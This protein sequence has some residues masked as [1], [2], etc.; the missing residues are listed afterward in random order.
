VNS[1]LK[2]ETAEMICFGKA[3]LADQIS[4]ICATPNLINLQSK[5]ETVDFYIIKTMMAGNSNLDMLAA[6]ATTQDENQ[7]KNQGTVYEGA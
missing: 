3:A 5:S 6:Q 7:C 1:N 4:K 2:K